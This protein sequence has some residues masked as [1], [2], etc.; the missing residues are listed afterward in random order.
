LTQIHPTAVVDREAEL[1]AGVQIGPYCIVEPGVE[2]G[3]GTRLESHVTI[4]TNTK[5]GLR[6]T[7]AQGAVL[8]GDPQD[9]KFAGEPTFLV[10]GNDN[11]IREYV[12]IHRASGEGNATVVGDRN[13]LMAFVHIGHNVRL[14][15]DVTIANSVG[16]SGHVTIEELVTIGGMTGIH[17]FVRIGKVAMIGGMSRIVRDVPPF[18]LV[19]GLEQTVHD[20]NA[21]GLRRIGVTQESR[22]ALHKACK[23]L[24]KSQLG[25]SNAIEIVRREVKDCYEIQYLLW[26]LERLYRGKSGRGDQNSE[27]HPPPPAR[28][29]SPV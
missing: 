29:A 21:V 14:H 4:K 23:L 25:L 17:Q 27:P 6:N 2:I 22:L 3:D 10:I 18:M 7:V 19:E 24:F 20:I 26:F 28:P 9:R 12:T 11:A 13:Y 15:D 16:V 8:G 5:L 1:G